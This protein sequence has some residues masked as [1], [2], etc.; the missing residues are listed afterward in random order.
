MKDV[1]GSQLKLIS[2]EEVNNITFTNTNASVPY[3]DI[4]SSKQI[5]QNAPNFF[6]QQGRLVTVSD[7]EFFVKSNFNNFVSDVKVVNN[8]EYIEEHIRYLYNIGLKQPSLDSRVLY[9]QVNFA[10][11]CNFNNI[12]IY[13]IPK[14]LQSN[15][16]NFNRC[17]L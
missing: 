4:E 13:C 8:W 3:S 10:D 17:F 9:N 5:K 14:L 15:E 7:F 12:Y 1:R 16:F 11:S 6:K 2:S